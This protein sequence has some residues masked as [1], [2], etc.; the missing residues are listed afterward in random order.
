MENAGLIFQTVQAKHFDDLKGFIPSV[1]AG[2][3]LA[4]AH[5]DPA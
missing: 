5:P 2:Y 3:R 1:R 4:I